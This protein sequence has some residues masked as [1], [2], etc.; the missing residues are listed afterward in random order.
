VDSQRPASNINPVSM[1]KTAIFLTVAVVSNS[2]GNLLLA[3]G[4]DRMPSFG[5]TGF[6]H[7]LFLLL[8]NPFLIPGAA[9]SATYMIAQLSLFS[10]ADLSFVVPVIASSY[11]IT[12]VLSEFILGEHVELQRWLGVV[13]ISLGVALVARTPP[14][15]KPHPKEGA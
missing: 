14:A 2:F 8:A 12:T 1:R 11:V 6:G 7:Y 3:I 15:T 4:M 13:L 9:L 10:W 5:G